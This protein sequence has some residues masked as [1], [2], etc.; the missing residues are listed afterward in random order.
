MQARSVTIQPLPRW[1]V[2]LL[3]IAA[4]AIP[5]S[6]LWDFSWE[7]TVGIDNVWAAPH[8]ANYLA[9]GLAAVAAAALLR[10]VNSPG[11]FGVR[12]GPWR[13]PLGGWIVAW[14]TLAFLAALLFDRWWMSSYGLAAGIWHPPQLLKA[15]AFFAVAMGTW[16]VALRQQSAAVAVQKGHGLASTVAGGLMMALITVVSLPLVYP[17]RQHSAS[18]YHVACATY[19]LVLIALVTSGPSRWSATMASLIYMAL[20]LAPIWVLPL[21]AAQPQVAPV[22]SPRT[23]LLPPPFPLLLV[24]PALGLDVWRMFSGP[25]GN[26][27]LWLQAGV[28][29]VLFF[30]LFAMTQWTFAE[31]LLTD[32]ADNWFFA[33]GGKHWPFFLKID[34]E[35]R[36]MFWERR[37][38]VFN[39]K[40]GAVALA[41]AILAAFIGLWIGKAMTRLKQ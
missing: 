25:A 29:G 20:L 3:L 39:F 8:V 38:D 37:T 24:I 40:S 15:V 13:G 1:A 12:L 11:Q 33:G 30:V 14:G 23:S 19:P 4:A 34:P 2:C 7:S 17:N 41:L 16:L 32:F 5:L 21:V 22:Y 10:P 6:L 36:T 18:F 31:F 35:A 9:L 28:M 27:R 26:R